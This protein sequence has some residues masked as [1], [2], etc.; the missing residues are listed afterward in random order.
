MPFILLI[1][2]GFCAAIMQTLLFREIFPVFQAG[3]FIIGISAA[4]FILCISIG[5]FIA[6]TEMFSKQKNLKKIILLCIPA[7]LISFIFSFIFIRD[8]RNILHIPLAEGISLKASFIY[9]FYALL[10]PSLFNGI[11]SL[12]I[13]RFFCKNAKQTLKKAVQYL[14][15]S[16]AA[17]FVFYSLFL[18]HISGF[19]IV[20]MISILMFM[21]FAVLIKPKPQVFV[22]SG[23]LIVFLFLMPKSIVTYL[24]KKTFA[25]NFDN[26][27]VLDFKYSAYGQNVIVK[28][29]NESILLSNHILNFSYPDNDIL[30][31]EDFVHISILHHENPKNVLI[32][33]GAVKYLPMILE[34]NVETID[35]VEQD[36]VIIDMIR[37][38]AAHLDNILNDKRLHIYNT[39]AR[40][41]IK[42]QKY[43]F[44]LI[45]LP[46]P[47]NL[48]LNSYYT[49]EFFQKAN[50]ALNKDGFLS[51]TLPGTMS[52]S[53]YL[54]AKLNKSILS[55]LETVFT[56]IE[57]LPGNR[58]I[59]TASQNKMPLRM[60]LKK[61]L[62]S[63]QNNTLILSKYYLDDKMDAEKIRWLHKEFERVEGESAINSDSDPQGMILSTLH[64]HSR[65]SPNLVIVFEFF[66]RYTYIFYFFVIAAFFLSKRVHP[67]TS[68]AFGM[69]CVWLN[70]IAAFSIQIYSGQILRF[71]GIILALMTTGIYI[72][73]ASGKFITRA[74]SSNFAVFYTEL[75]QCLWIIC[76]VVLFY[77][78]LINTPIILFFVFGTSFLC[79]IE[80]NAL[81]INWDIL[82][83]YADKKF[84]IYFALIIGAW[85]AALAGGGFLILVMGIQK[86]LIFMLFIKFLI[87]CRWADLK[88]KIPI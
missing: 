63:M 73:A 65:F 6:S 33:S 58:N 86:S 20:F 34:H 3:D 9:L 38:D 18:F 11:L 76:W 16:I 72:G 81:I 27:E 83:W 25:K 23:L 68:F 46:A 78:N 35:Y 52:F 77:L 13:I 71:A 61:R 17:G 56:F 70:L 87:L 19:L 74:M 84:R 51:L 55:S 31:S 62:S 8:L 39:D 12:T 82:H 47:I 49:K 69:S 64:W 22:L 24:D 21:L 54:M 80:I 79:G 66:S 48:N 7:L 67:E 1:V 41:F 14:V 59:L 60:Q 29:N 75:A 57:I 40:E 44:I 15:L 42:N 45:G 85:L 36:G 88:K 37:N 4:H 32:I 30:G 43:D 5:L 53:T 26:A 28:S 2:F 10:P 50:K